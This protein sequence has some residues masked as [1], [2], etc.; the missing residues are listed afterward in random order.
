[1]RIYL[2]CIPCFFRQALRAARLVLQDEGKIRELLSELGDTLKEL[3][4]ESNPPEMGKFIY[5][6]IREISGTLDPY[7]GLKKANIRAA[8]A[9]YP[10]LKDYVAGSGDR[11]E[12]AIRVAA[13]GNSIDF[14]V[15]GQV[16][17]FERLEEIESMEFADFDYPL[18]RERLEEAGKVLYLGDNAAE[19]V[20]DR[21]L[22]EEIPGPVAFA[23][24]EVPVIND[25]T[26][27]EAEMAGIAERAE[28]ISTGG[29][30]PGVLIH[31]SSPEFIERLEKS[32][33]TISKGQGNYEGLADEK[34]PVFH[35]LKVKCPIIA[36]DIGIPAGKFV[37]KGRN[38]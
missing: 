28:V 25:V 31:D 23:V 30:A 4:P 34:Y 6:R 18:F 2:D 36:D 26:R 17:V 22:V 14:G 33:L 15:F 1:M 9:I 13:A 3:S 7:A 35:L 5:R 19:S 11:L 21:V 20:F 32:P 10:R 38:I 8:L 12:A 16:D 24:R 37:F 29:Q 27:E